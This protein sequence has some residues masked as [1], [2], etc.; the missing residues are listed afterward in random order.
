M[1]TIAEVE[2]ELDERIAYW[3]T[4]EDIEFDEGYLEALKDFK[5]WVTKQI[6]EDIIND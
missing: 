5:L 1:T 3:G 2:A 4:D 6:E